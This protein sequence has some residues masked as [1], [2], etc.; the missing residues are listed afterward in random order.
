MDRDQDSFGFVFRVGTF[1]V[2]EA[3]G[4]V[5]LLHLSQEGRMDAMCRTF[6]A[7]S[8]GRSY[9]WVV[10][11]VFVRLIVEFRHSPSR[12]VYGV[13]VSRSLIGVAIRKTR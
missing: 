7:F 2:G 9:A 10:R 13:S 12:A 5:C 6:V 4:D 3:R 1:G 11:R 8:F